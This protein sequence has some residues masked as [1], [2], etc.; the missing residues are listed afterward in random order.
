VSAGTGARRVSVHRL[1]RR[2]GPASALMLGVGLAVAAVA[3]V[4]PDRRDIP[5]CPLHA[6]TGLLCPLCGGLRAVNH[7][8]HG[9]LGAALHSNVVVVLALPL[10]LA[11]W[12]SGSRLISRPPVAQPGSLLRAVATGVAAL[13][14]IA[15]TVARNLPVGAQLRPS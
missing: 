8:A 6:M 11:L 9:H 15:F 3:A 7:L 1:R 12:L 4:D 2:L 13:L 10:G 5:L 14:L